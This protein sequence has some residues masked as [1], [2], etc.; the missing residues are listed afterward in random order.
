M[1]KPKGATPRESTDGMSFFAAMLIGVVLALGIMLFVYL[2]NPFKKPQTVDANPATVQ[3]KSTAV[4]S[5]P[6]YEFYDLLKEQQVS[7]ILNQPIASQTV[8]TNASPD[9]V[10]TAPPTARRDKAT[11][12]DQDPT[13]PNKVSTVDNPMASDELSSPNPD[14]IDDKTLVTGTTKKADK[15]DKADAKAHIV[16]TEADPTRTYILQINSFDN[17][18]DADK[19]RAEVLIAGV[20]A[21]IVKKHLKDGGLVYQVISRPMPNSQMAGEAQR[22]LQS[23][24]IDSL[25]VEQRRN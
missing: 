19:R 10:I 7:G 5:A 16:I 3:P 2:W 21:Q 24:G 11:A 15:A 22:R 17:A 9:V 18:D 12:T 13:D 8:A 4:A 6:N 23:S 14:D 25:I 1:S 20:D